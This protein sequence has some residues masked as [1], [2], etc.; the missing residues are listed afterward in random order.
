MTTAAGGT[1]PTD[2]TTIFNTVKGLSEVADTTSGGVTTE[3]TL[4]HRKT[5][6]SDS[7]SDLTIFSATIGSRPE[8]KGQLD[9]SSQPIIE[10]DSGDFTFFF[11]VDYQDALCG[12]F[13]DGSHLGN[14]YDLLTDYSFYIDLIQHEGD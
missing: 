11:N 10:N 14:T 12:L 8:F 7:D 13:Y 2:A 4:L 9:S 5:F 1:L 3:G 6:A